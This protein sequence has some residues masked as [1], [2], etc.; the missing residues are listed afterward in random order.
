MPS[1]TASYP[2]EFIADSFPII[3]AQDES[4]KARI[5]VER[6]TALNDLSAT[7]VDVNF[8]YEN[9]Y[10]TP[11]SNRQV[12]PSKVRVRRQ[13]DKI[14]LEVVGDIAV[15]TA[16]EPWRYR[17]VGEEIILANSSFPLAPLIRISKAYFEHLAGAASSFRAFGAL[18]DEQLNEAE[19]VDEERQRL[20]RDIAITIDKLLKGQSIRFGDPETGNLANFSE[21]RYLSTAFLVHILPARI[22]ENHFFLQEKV[23]PKYDFRRSRRG[24]DPQ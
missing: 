15:N 2:I 5:I 9:P 1:V 3:G 14:I 16:D 23:R 20:H 8:S 22:F 13:D 18:Y 11:E 6:T 24:A 17:T 12:H 10:P 21:W 4:V 19:T 7:Y